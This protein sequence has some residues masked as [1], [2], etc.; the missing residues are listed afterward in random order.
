MVKA[1]NFSKF[2]SVTTELLA[3]DVDNELATVSQSKK[4]RVSS[5]FWKQSSSHRQM[6][7][8]P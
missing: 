8:I 3:G 5:P 4:V 6:M 2:C 7:L 1:L